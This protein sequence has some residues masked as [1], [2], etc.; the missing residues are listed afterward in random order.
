MLSTTIIEKPPFLEVLLIF[1]SFGLLVLKILH[2]LIFLAIKNN[3][4][5]EIARNTKPTKGTKI[6]GK[7][8]CIIE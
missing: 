1:I 8:R 6:E 2:K 7:F 3:E 5:I 4:V